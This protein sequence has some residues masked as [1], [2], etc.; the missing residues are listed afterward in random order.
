M[1]ASEE[2]VQENADHVTEEGSS[3][4][5]SD[6]GLNSP[7]SKSFTEGECHRETCRAKNQS[8]Q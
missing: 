8:Y 3:G 6:E 2:D 4:A 7:K 5:A 1:I